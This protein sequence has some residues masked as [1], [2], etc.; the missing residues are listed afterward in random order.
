VLTLVLQLLSAQVFVV[1]EGVDY[2]TALYLCV[3]TATTVGYGDVPIPTD[4]GR[5]F[6]ASIM[7]LDVVL[8]AELFSTLRTIIAARSEL[9]K[10][11]RQEQALQNKT[12]LKRLL[13]CAHR[14]RSVDEKSSSTS[15]RQHA[16]PAAQQSTKR[17]QDEFYKDLTEDSSA[18]GISESEFAMAMLI[19]TGAVESQKVKFFLRMFRQLDWDGNGELNLRDLE[20]DKPISYPSSSTSSTTAPHQ[21]F[22]LRRV[23]SSAD[24]DGNAVCHDDANRSRA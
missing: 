4:G 24:W 11:Y 1:I 14:L 6:A 18:F 20:T 17:E 22:K 12:L 2:S 8:L 15:H 19:E 13:W 23:V 5:L 9:A 10:Q 7:L 16:Q 3:V 21:R